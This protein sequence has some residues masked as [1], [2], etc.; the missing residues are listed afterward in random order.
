M[1]VRVFEFYDDFGSWIKWGKYGICIG[2]Y[3][4]MC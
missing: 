4:K 2:N 3:A 1:E